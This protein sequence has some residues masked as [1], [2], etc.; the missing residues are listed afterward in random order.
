MLNHFASEPCPRPPLVK[1]WLG[2]GGTS[3][4][5]A[6]SCSGPSETSSTGAG[7]S[8]C[9]STGSLSLVIALQMIAV[10]QIGSVG[11]HRLALPGGDALEVLDVADDVGA[12]VL[13]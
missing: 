6:G 4:G 10:E 8:G 13:G 5:F 9:V 1:S 3:R 11:A 7:T 2:I 12:R